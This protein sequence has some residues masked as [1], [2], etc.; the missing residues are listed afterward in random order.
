[1][2]RQH[3]YLLERWH[4]TRQLAPKQWQ[5]ALD[6]NPALNFS[7]EPV[8]KQNDDDQ[9]SKHTRIEGELLNS[10]IGFHAE[11]DHVREQNQE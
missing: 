9:Q 10:R 7:G 6:S 3:Q 11:D 2:L 4:H 1:V 8:N 5:H